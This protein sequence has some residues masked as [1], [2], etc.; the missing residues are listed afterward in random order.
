M[1]G[2]KIRLR[3]VEESDLN[4][5]QSLFNDDHLRDLVVGWDFPVS[6]YA[7]KRW[8][9]SL[10]SGKN[11]I[12]LIIETHEGIAIGLTGLWDIDWH[13]RNALTAVKLKGD[14][15]K[16]KG[17]GRDAIMTMNAF[18][19]F[20]V[21]LH[22][23]W[24]SIID[25]NIPSFKVYVDKSGWKT[26]GV[27]R[28]HVFRNGVFHNLYYVGCLKDDFLNVPDSGD[29]VPQPIP[30]GMKKFSADI[31]KNEISKG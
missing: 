25:Y 2:K 24:G 1:T 6:M 15:V 17:Y 4:F 26:E 10:S 21:G 22:R 18:S 16:G 20:D 12:R 31:F 13:N 28:D 5:C 30:A 7:Q 29:Y 11:N 27:L 14:L 19:F 3:V 9:E 8:F 23:L